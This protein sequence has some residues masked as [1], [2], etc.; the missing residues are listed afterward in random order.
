MEKFSLFKNKQEIA[1][2][3]TI[4]NRGDTDFLD[5]FYA[6]LLPLVPDAGEENLR[7]KVWSHINEDFDFTI[8]GNHYSVR[9]YGK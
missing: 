9:Y 3:E 6:I 1:Q 8:N 7:N 2:F 4:A 5:E